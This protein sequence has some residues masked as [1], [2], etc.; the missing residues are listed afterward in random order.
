MSIANHMSSST[1]EVA[2][3]E[4]LCYDLYTKSTLANILTESCYE[5]KP[6]HM[7]MSSIT[8]ITD[9]THDTRMQ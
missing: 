2:V 1:P 7:N 6:S 9:Q 3:H 4:A 5:N 8:L